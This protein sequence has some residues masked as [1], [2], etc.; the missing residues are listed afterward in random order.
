MVLNRETGVDVLSIGQ[1]NPLEVHDVLS[2][3][4]VC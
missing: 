1:V 4:L 2:A 3:L